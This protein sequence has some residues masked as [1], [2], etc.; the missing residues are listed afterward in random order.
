M[1]DPPTPF[2]C[3]GCHPPPLHPF[4]RPF[5][6]CERGFFAGALGMVLA[7]R[8]GG[9]IDL[10]PTHGRWLVR[11]LAAAGCEARLAAV[12]T[13]PVPNPRG[14]PTPPRTN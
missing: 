14:G 10:C 12:A 8:Q 2:R 6:D 11:L 3:I 5:T 13:E 9:N 7:Q 4:D 1:D